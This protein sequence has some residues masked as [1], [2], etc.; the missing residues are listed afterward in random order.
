MKIRYLGTAAAEGVPAVF[1][2][3]GH[4]TNARKLKGKE[5]RSRAQAVI[6]DDLMIDLGPDTYQSALRFGVDLSAIKYLL[7]THTHE[8]HFLPFELTVR[9]EGY[10]KDMVQ[11]DIY[12]YGNNRVKERYDHLLA[13][14]M[15]PQI[16]AGIHFC[17]LTPF[18]R[19]SIGDYQ[20]TPLPADH[21]LE[22]SAFVYL[23]EKD[24]KSILYL[25][26]TGRRIDSALQYLGSLG[27]TLD[28]I[29][30]DCTYGIT[31]AGK[32]NGHM[33]I[34]DNA[35]M[36]ERM[37]AEG[38]AGQHTYAMSTHFSHWYL[39]P[40]EKLQKLASELSLSVAY[41]GI[42]ITI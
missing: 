40:F 29:G 6:N 32:Y 37:R 11:K 38:I 28:F 42:E 4:C 23:I 8:D 26:D 9:G 13:E 33:S 34:Y 19:E 20:V 15:P 30:F 5:Y 39:I 35:L 36:L 3:C 21:M 7:I 41:D 25:N 24:G 17:Q 31:E 22:E 14:R 27:T 18:K 1:C 12:I 16:A 2:N 10:A